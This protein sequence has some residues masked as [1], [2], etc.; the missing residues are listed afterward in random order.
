MDE[1]VALA[2]RSLAPMLERI[3]F[4]LEQLSVDGLRRW[5]LLGNYWRT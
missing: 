4:L 3:G 2:P 1:L 5:A